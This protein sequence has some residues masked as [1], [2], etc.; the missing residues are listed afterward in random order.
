MWDCPVLLRYPQLQVQS[1]K[2]HNGGENYPR[3]V[4]VRGWTLKSI[5][6]EGAQGPHTSSHPNYTRVTM[7]INKCVCV[8]GQSIDLLLDTGA[9]YRVLTESPGSLSP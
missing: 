8:W 9:T 3:G 7:G 5:R 4:G 1:E 6:V 2:D